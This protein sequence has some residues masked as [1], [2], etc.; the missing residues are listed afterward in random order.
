MLPKDFP[1]WQAVYWHFRKWRQD[2]RIEHCIEKLV[3]KIRRKRRQNELPTVGALDAQSVK[4]GNR[5]SDNGFDA[6][7]RLTGIKRN[8]VVDRTD[9]FLAG[10][11]T[12][13]PNM[14]PNWLSDF[15]K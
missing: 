4:W 5:H 1:Q 6:N 14:I 12:Q 11:S 3:M 10:L 2:G 8:I 13:R 9:S 15:V 7:K